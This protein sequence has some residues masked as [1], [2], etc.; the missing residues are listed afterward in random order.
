MKIV[1]ITDTHL[2][3]H[4]GTTNENL[5]RVATFLNDVVRPAAV[6]HTGDVII[7]DPDQHEDRTAAKEL[8]ERIEAPLHVLPGN[9]DIGDSSQPWL[10]SSDRVAAHRDVFGPDRWVEIV[11]DVALVGLNS[12]IL[13]TGLPEEAEQEAWLETL[14]ELTGG[15]RSLVFHHKPL[16]NPDPASAHP[17]GVV[18]AAAPRLR[19]LLER[20]DV[21]AYGSGH[22]HRY[23]LERDGDAWSVSAPATAFTAGSA[24]D[25]PGLRQLGFVEYDVTAEAVTPIFRTVHTLVERDLRDLPEVERALTEAGFVIPA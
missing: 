15:R 10:V 3:R 6:V 22:L 9:H 20:I 5:L 14:P 16:R 11:G 18:P 8:L 21:V 17:M 24:A 25:Y 12:E 1:Q 7:M 23:L 4:G 2:T 19:A 13:G